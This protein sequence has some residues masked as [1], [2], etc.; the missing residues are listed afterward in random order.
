MRRL[1]MNKTG[2]RVT[3]ADRGEYNDFSAIS[4]E[5]EEYEGFL[6]SVKKEGGKPPTVYVDLDV[7]IYDNH[8]RANLHF[9][10]TKGDKKSIK[11]A[12]DRMDKVLGVLG[13]VEQVL[14]EAS[15]E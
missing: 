14:L 11:K 12:R 3:L 1:N 6:S 7:S 10:Y 4:Y 9:G 5:Y 15:D 2:N 8:D 13:D